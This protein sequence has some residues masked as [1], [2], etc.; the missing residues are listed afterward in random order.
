RFG[1]NSQFTSI[2]AR[3][4]GGAPGLDHIGLLDA[5]LTY[6]I[7][8]GEHGRL[9]L[10]GGLSSA[11]APDII[12][13]GPDVGT[14]AA[15]G[16]AGPVGAEASLHLTPYPYVQVDGYA[17]LTLTLGPAGLRAGWRHVYL[18][19]RGLVDGVVNADTFSGPFLGLSLSM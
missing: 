10:E 17:G 6:A 9:R 15:M 12:F 18:N 11:F 8:R 4:E 2:F 1:F 16:I 7:L 19:D 14:S 5:H 3:A 13:V